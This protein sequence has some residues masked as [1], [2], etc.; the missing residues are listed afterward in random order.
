M[1]KE[2]KDI[3]I[4]EILHPKR[5]ILG[6]NMSVIP[7]RLLRILALTEAVNEKDADSIIYRAGKKSENV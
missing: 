5:S 6:N 2:L 3:P 7:W 4:E 1:P